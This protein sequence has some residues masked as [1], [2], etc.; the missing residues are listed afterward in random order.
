[1]GRANY[2]TAIIADAVQFLIQCETMVI[3][4]VNLSDKL[5]YKW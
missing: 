2:C 3:A 5:R 4:I 1:M